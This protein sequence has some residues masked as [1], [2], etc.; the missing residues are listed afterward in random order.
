MNVIFTCG[1]TGGHINPAIAVANAWKERYPD[2]KILFVGGEGGLE[3]ELVPKAGY[4][5]EV[6][7]GGGLAR[8]KSLKSM[9]KN[10][11]V[12]YQ[13]MRTV[14]KCKRI[15]KDFGASI[16]VGTGG[17]AS[18][19]ALMAATMLKIP[20]CVHEANAM[21]G[22]TTRLIADRADRVLV[23][24][25]ESAQHYKHPEKVEVVGMPV[26][27]EF[28]YTKR[29]DARKELNLDD[30]PL[31]VSAFGS[32]GSENMNEITAELFKL[33]MEAGFPFQHIHAVGNYGWVWMPDLVK[34]KGVDL[35]K[36][37]S[38]RMQQYIYNMPTVMAAADVFISRAGASSCN[39]IAASG[40]PCILI[41]SPNVTDNHQEK[42]ARSLEKVGAAEVLLDKDTT[43]Q[44]L[45]E[46]I[47]LLLQDKK[48]WS[49]MR[50]ALQSISV[51]DCAERLCG[52]MEKLIR[53]K[54]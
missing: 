6:L 16:V 43:A 18:F 48:R 22:L 13:L 33:E 32:N 10:V 12:V 30:R 20:T 41:P 39:E 36:C 52:I 40:T 17:Y 29:E 44:S 37:P 9:V 28:I 34:E 47:T 11:K 3:E 49:D 14:S 38:I 27:R 5:L 24:F 4:A 26:R 15:I 2:S 7:P 53:T 1:G 45:M 42:N 25:P 8:G 23:C 50:A 46:K 35:N 31:I 19:P 51:P 21:P 54:E